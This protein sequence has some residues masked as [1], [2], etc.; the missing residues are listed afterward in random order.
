MC[1]REMQGV[2]L[3]SFLVV[4]RNPFLQEVDPVVGVG[5]L[6][7]VFQGKHSKP[8]PVGHGRLGSSHTLGVP[9]RAKQELFA[10]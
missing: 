4:L 3:A 9:S 5:G 8:I 7:A 1:T 6:A 2:T 10:L